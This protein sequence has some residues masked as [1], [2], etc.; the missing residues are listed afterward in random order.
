M[1][2]STLITVLEKMSTLHAYLYELTVRKEEVV[3]GN[4]VDELQQITREEQ[5]YTRAIV[6]L[7]KQREQLSGNKTISEVAEVSSPEEKTVLLNLKEKL[8]DT[9][10]KIK[11][12][13]E[14]NQSLLQQSL[15]FVTMTMN[16]LNPQP[17]AV[18]YE[19]PANSKK[20]P[21]APGRSLF[22]SKA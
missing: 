16:T 18:N 8:L 2:T 6:Q 22:D 17:T 20:S 19:K 4:K 12:Q 15:Q 5:Q 11:V 21:S 9:I 3:K 14:L 13:N 1:S 7:E 10:E